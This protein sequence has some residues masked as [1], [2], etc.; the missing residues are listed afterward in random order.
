MKYDY[1]HNTAVHHRNVITN[2][3]EVVLSRNLPEDAIERA[4]QAEVGFL[5][6]EAWD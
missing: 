1:F 3:I 4:F 6:G 5:A 2:A